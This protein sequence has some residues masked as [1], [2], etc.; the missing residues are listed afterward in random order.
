MTSFLSLLIAVLILSLATTGLEAQSTQSRKNPR[1][2]SI[3]GRV[4]VIGAK[5]SAA[6]AG[7]GIL[8]FGGTYLRTGLVGAIGAT[9]DGISSRADGFALFHLDPFRESHWAPY[10]G[11]GISGRFDQGSRPRAYLLVFAGVD[12]PVKNGLTTSFEAGLGGGVRL[13]VIIRQAVA[14]RR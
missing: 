7:I 2:T 13:G 12:G 1:S 11:A 10:G 6:Q 4:D 3:E 5:N 9:R 8:M 14:E